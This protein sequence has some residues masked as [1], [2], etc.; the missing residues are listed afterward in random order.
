MEV[1]LQ[2]G[3]NLVGWLE[4]AG[5]AGSL[6]D[7]IPALEAVMV[8][9]PA[10]WPGTGLHWIP[11]DRSGTTVVAPG[12]ALWLKIAAERPSVWRQQ[13]AAVAPSRPLAAGWQ[14]VVWSWGAE[15]WDG[16]GAVDA[17]SRLYRKP[18]TLGPWDAAA[19]GVT[20]GLREVWRWDARTQRF[21]I[22]SRRGSGSEDLYEGAG[23]SRGEVLLLYLQTA[24]EWR[25][26]D[27]PAVLGTRW[28]SVQD[29]SRLREALTEA[30]SG[31]AGTLGLDPPTL[32]VE[33][34]RIGFGCLTGGGVGVVKLYLPCGSIRKIVNSAVIQNYVD[35]LV[36]KHEQSGLSEPIW[37]AGGTAHYSALLFQAE[38]RL[39]GYEEA[40]DVLIGLARSSPL[41][42]T[43]AYFEGY[44]PW[45]GP[46]WTSSRE[47]LREA[48]W[49]LAVDW[50]AR[51]YGDQ[52]VRAY[53]EG[54]QS[55]PWRDAFRSSFGISAEHALAQFGRY[56]E[57]LAADGR[58]WSNRPFQQIMFPGAMTEQRWQTFDI[59]EEIIDFF[60]KQH[61][62][63]ASSV[64]FMLDLDSTIYS[65]LEGSITPQSCGRAQGGLVMLSTTCMYPFIIAHE[66]AHVLQ[67]D[68]REGGRYT[69][70][71]TW[72]SEG[73]ADY[74]ALEYRAVATEQDISVLVTSIEENTASLVRSYS[75]R[76]SYLAVAER[77]LADRPYAVGSLAV[78][79]LVRWGGFDALWAVFAPSWERD[80]PLYFAAQTGLSLER[81]FDD[82]GGW[83]RAMADSQSSLREDKDD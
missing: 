32:V 71:P 66:Y 54:R 21:E 24:A 11:I 9:A 46:L 51:G 72:L 23:I 70:Q 53:I 7:R 22:L 33:V 77:A 17:M 12:E 56:R 67:H 4:A 47:P 68:E 49:N 43:S 18:F 29:D 25:T 16:P 62:R 5:P 78:R 44:D 31:F 2:A 19:S 34:H 48:L 79:H 27:G 76:L 6:F 26:P 81:F 63:S 38:R 73:A 39:L 74:L 55:V 41:P 45:V 61:G 75:E 37:L 40:R 82:F 14:A 10:P 69:P 35:T 1:Q 64:T 58:F 80:F 83:L 59:V 60:A 36:W 65:Q 3:W 50:L 13:P 30:E 8:R 15:G 42:V 57:W 28:M 52:A 20:D